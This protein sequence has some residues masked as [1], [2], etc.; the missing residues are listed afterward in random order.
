MVTSVASLVVILT[1]AKSVSYDV[2]AFRSAME[3]FCG[4]A[5]G[6][7]E[8]TTTNGSEIS[9]LLL[10]TLGFAIFIATL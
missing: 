1:D 3:I 9:V 8:G 10:T 5:N 7:D 2:T 6:A 4:I